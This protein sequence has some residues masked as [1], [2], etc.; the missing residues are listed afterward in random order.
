M[1]SKIL[2][3]IPQS[4]KEAIR[5]AYRDEDGYWICLHEG[6]EA[7]RTDS[8]CRTIHEDKISDLKYQIAGIQRIE[9]AAEVESNAE[10]PEIATE[11]TEATSEGSAPTE[12]ENAAE[13]AENAH[14]EEAADLTISMPGLVVSLPRDGFTDAAL[15]NLSKLVD[16]KASL[17]S[18][19]LGTDNLDITVDNETVSFPWW[20]R[21]PDPDEV[22][23]Y[24]AFIAAIA[25]MA[26]EA[27]R[28]NATADREI[29]SEKYAFRG[30]L[31]RLGFIGPGC[32]AQR[33]ILLKRLSGAAAF[34]SNDK[35]SAFCSTQK[36][37]R[38][39][40]KEVSE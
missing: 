38:D 14:S 7:S 36:A 24:M 23:A 1:D 21:M 15:E 22:Q 26:K 19:A 17:I 4:K 34:P 35:Y 39:A 5:D 6:W 12:A 32:A 13:G 33:K 11:A 40:A 10:A 25:R 3:Y 18:K 30:F 20:D 9:E 16:A 8:G 37:K 2:N 27:K 28:V 29:E 31:L